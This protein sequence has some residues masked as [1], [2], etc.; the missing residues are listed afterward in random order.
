MHEV[1]LHERVLIHLRKYHGISITEEKIAPYE[2][3]QDGVAMALGISRNHTSV[4]LSRMVQN[5]DVTFVIS[6]I[7]HSESGMRRKAYSLTQQG[8][9]RY[10]AMVGRLEDEGIGVEDLLL[11]NNVNYFSGEMLDSIPK[12]DMDII[13]M[14]AVIRQQ[15]TREELNEPIPANMPFDGKGNVMMKEETRRRLIGRAQDTVL[16]RWH[17]LAAD[18]CAVHCGDIRE[19]IMH[20]AKAGRMLE[21]ERMIDRNRFIIMDNPSEDIVPVALDMSQETSRATIPYVAAMVSIRSMMI[22]EARTAIAH[23]EHLD[24]ELAKVMNV[25]L[26]LARGDWRKAL[27]MAQ[28]AYRGDAYTSLA[29]GK[30]MVLAHRLDEALGYLRESREDMCRRGCT[31]RMDEELRIEASVMEKLGHTEAGRML[32]DVADSLRM[33]ICPEGMPPDKGVCSEDGVLL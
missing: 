16:K 24:P 20:L 32:H 18:W 10:E 13:G 8:V 31:F 22:P 6:R 15:V 23:L 3:T 1:N 25:E 9:E 27:A 26:E 14:V 7:R 11:P 21:A 5:G 29:L 4:I 28:G 33:S 2:L 30:S 12:Q 19:R 17:S